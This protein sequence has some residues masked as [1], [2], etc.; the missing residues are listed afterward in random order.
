MSVAYSVV[1]AGVGD[2]VLLSV[3]HRIVYGRPCTRIT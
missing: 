1:E 2:W 3:V